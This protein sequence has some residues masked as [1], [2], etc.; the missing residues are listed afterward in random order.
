MTQKTEGWEVRLSDYLQEKHAAPFVRAEHD[1]ALFAGNCVEIMTGRDVT[2]EFRKPYKSKAAAEKFLKSL[3][4][5]D[6]EAV[7]NAKL[8]EKLPS[9]AFAG[10]GDCVMIEVE[11]EQALGIVDLS[12]RR[13]A[14]V[15]KDGLVYFPAKNW[16]SAWK[17]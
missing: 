9:T 2:S 12:G 13:A 11:G 7:A 6:L 8:G 10:R 15:G 5:D 1:C 16:V 14:T 3:G 4:Y 17:V